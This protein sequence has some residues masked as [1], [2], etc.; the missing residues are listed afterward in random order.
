MKSIIS[1]SIFVAA[2]S[3]LFACSETN[4]SESNSEQ[5]TDN[6]AATN[7]AAQSLNLSLPKKQPSTK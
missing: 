3:L 4:H 1:R 7:T 6:S 5:N 2:L